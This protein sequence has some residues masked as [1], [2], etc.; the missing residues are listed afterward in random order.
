VQVLG[1]IEKVT[2][3]AP[4]RRM[5]DLAFRNPNATLDEFRRAALETETVLP[6]FRKG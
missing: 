2:G 4:E 6:H 3:P 5:P 1:E